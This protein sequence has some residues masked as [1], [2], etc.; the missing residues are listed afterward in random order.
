MVS[1]K[2]STSL[3]I[4]VVFPLQRNNAIFNTINNKLGTDNQY[5]YFGKRN[6]DTSLMR[7]DY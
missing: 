5:A 1:F 2:Q 7:Y 6:P 3:F 4:T